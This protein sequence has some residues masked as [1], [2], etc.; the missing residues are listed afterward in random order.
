[1]ANAW[2][3]HAGHGGVAQLPDTEAWRARGWE[4]C[5]PPD[6]PDPT[7]EVVTEAPPSAGLFAAQPEADEETEDNG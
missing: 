7:R 4:P 6:E 5:E 1:M 2:M 3:R